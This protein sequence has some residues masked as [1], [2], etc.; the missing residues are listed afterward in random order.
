M[1]WLA[2]KQCPRRRREHDVAATGDPGRSDVAL[3]TLPL[4][5]PARR[6]F[7]PAVH[8]PAAGG[9]TAS[10]AAYESLEPGP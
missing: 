3:V 5:D 9:G 1:L 2:W 6:L 7:R 10:E 4:V 8:S